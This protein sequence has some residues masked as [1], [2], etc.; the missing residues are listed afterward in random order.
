M[1]QLA[2]PRIE[3]QEQ[4]PPNV[5]CNPVHAKPRQFGPNETM[6][7]YSRRYGRCSAQCPHYRVPARRPTSVESSD[8]GAEASEHARVGEPNRVRRRL[9]GLAVPDQVFSPLYSE[10]LLVPQRRQAGGVGEDPA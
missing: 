6:R 9:D 8:S 5:T 1:S 3:R 4:L 7:P 2:P 10:Q